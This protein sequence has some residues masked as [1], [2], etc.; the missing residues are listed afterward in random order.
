MS[1]ETKG[2]RGNW[3]TSQSLLVI[4]ALHRLKHNKRNNKC[5]MK[6]QKTKQK[7]K[8]SQTGR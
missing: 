6:D 5:K 8:M 2:T 3:M 7:I 1:E 4:K